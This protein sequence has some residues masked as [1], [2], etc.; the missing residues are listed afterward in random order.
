MANLADLKALYLAKATAYLTDDIQLLEFKVA[1]DSWYNA[2][3]ALDTSTAGNVQSYSIAGRSV[4]RSTLTDL[5]QDVARLY[6]EMRGYLYG[7]EGGRVDMSGSDWASGV[8][9]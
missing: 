5:R 1:L 8:E 7:G 2:R 3:L 6:A 9:T 4:T